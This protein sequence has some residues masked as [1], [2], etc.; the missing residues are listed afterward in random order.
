LAKETHSCREQ[1]KKMRKK[2]RKMTANKLFYAVKLPSSRRR[3]HRR[4]KHAQWDRHSFQRK[5]Y[6][7]S[8]FISSKW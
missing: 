5:I 6:H 8:G 7:K 3:A 4:P 2:R 1:E